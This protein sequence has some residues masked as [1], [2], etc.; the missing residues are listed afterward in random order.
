MSIENG[1]SNSCTFFGLL[2]MVIPH[3]APLE[4]KRRVVQLL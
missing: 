2:C 4:R 1:M 3:T